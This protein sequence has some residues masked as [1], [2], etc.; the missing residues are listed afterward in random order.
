M[1]LIATTRKLSVVT[2][3]LLIVSSSARAALI[4]PGAGVLTPASVPPLG[5]LLFGGVPVPFTGP[6]PNGFSG[7]I[8]SSVYGPDAND[9]AGD[10]FTYIIHNNVNSPT[11][12]EGI[13]LP[14]FS[15]FATD[16][17]YAVATGQ[18]PT[19]TDRSINAGAVLTWHFTGVGGG[20]LGTIL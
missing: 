19:S 8:T 4:L 7:T 11:A 17:S 15:G 10:T 16:V 6:G 9:P 14:D 20:G 12:L 1:S 3:V 18:V 2:L 13:V 5:A